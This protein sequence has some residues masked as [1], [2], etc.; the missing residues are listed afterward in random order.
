MN[1]STLIKIFLLTAFVSHVSSAALEEAIL[2]KTANRVPIPIFL[3]RGCKIRSKSSSVVAACFS[4]ELCRYSCRCYG[5]RKDRFSIICGPVP[6]F[7]NGIINRS[8][9]VIR[10]RGGSVYGTTGRLCGCKK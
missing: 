10:M 6:P 3:R 2:D 5:L 7:Y 9:A 1:P 8:R 4:N